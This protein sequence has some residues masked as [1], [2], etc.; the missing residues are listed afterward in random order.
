MSDLI[1]VQFV[2]KA[3]Q[4]AHV[5]DI[6][7]GMVK[8]TRNEPGNIRYDLFQSESADGRKRFNLIERYKDA[9]AVAAHRETDHYKKYR[10]DISSLLD[11][12]IAVT[13]LT[14]L[15]VTDL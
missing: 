11:D 7:R 9:A 14:A 8:S 6:L 1:F 3:G 13:F 4:E 10:L 12:P 5:E 15:D 2:P